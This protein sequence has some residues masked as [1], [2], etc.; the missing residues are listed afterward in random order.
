MASGLQMVVQTED[1]KTTCVHLGPEQYLTHQDGQLKEHIRVQVT[2]AT[3]K[4][5]GQPVRRARAGQLDGHTLTL[6]NA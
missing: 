2:G 3:A 4:V 5:E 6:R 1:A